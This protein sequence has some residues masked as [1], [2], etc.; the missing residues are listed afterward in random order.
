MQPIVARRR[1][2]SPRH[3]CFLENALQESWPFDLSKS[4]FV[5]TRAKHNIGHIDDQE[6][7]RDIEGIR[8]HGTVV[9]GTEHNGI[10]P[11]S[12][13]SEC[14]V[15][16]HIPCQEVEPGGHIGELKALRDVESDWDHQS[17]GEGNQIDGRQCRKDGAMSSAHRNSKRVERRPL[18]T[19]EARQQRQ[20]GRCV[21]NVPRSSMAP[22]KH[23]RHPITLPNPPRRRGQLKL[24]TRKIRRSTIRRSTHQ[25]ILLY[26]GQSRRIEHIRYIAYTVQRLGEHPTATMNEKD[27]PS[28]DWG[29]CSRVRQHQ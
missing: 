21:N 3:P 9:D 19:E 1:R 24:R 18:A 27:R 20:Y 26:Q 22:R 28:D 16:T 23:P 15:E 13:G 17:D 2:G 7:L 29:A 4:M 12:N 5:S 6:A 10:P 8:D 14:E 11:S 25:V